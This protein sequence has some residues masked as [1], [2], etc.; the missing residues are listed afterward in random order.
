MK[1]PKPYSFKPLAL[2]CAL[3]IGTSA[4]DVFASGT[5]RI[6]SIDD[7][8]RRPV[9]DVKVT[10]TARDGSKSEHSGEG[11]SETIVV[12]GLDAGLY[13]ITI[14]H[15]NYYPLRLPS[16]RVID[17]KTTPLEAEL[18]ELRTTVEET[19]VIGSKV[20][21]NFLDPVSSSEKDREALRSS[22]GGGGDVLRSLDGLPGLF[23]DSAF[24]SY[25][26]R[27]NGPRDNLILVDGIPFADV[28]HFS[29]ALGEQE[30]LEGGGRYSVFAPNI[31]ANAEFQPGGWEPA[32]GGLAGSLL[33]LEVAEGN[34]DTPSYTVRFDV[35]G[36]EIG[37]DGPTYIHD[38]TSV[39]FSARSLD[40][41]RLFETI[42]ND[43]LGEPSL[44]DVIL[45]TS[46]RYEDDK[47]NFLLLHSTEDYRRDIKHVIASDEDEVG[48]YTN[49]SL[50]NTERDNALYALTWDHLLANNGELIQRFYYRTF[51][52]SSEIGEA[53]P[54]LVPV[55]SPESAVPTR[56]DL[57]YSMR[58]EKETGY[59]LD[60]AMPNALGRFS[61][62]LRVTQVDLDF[63]LDLRDDWIRYTYSFKDFRPSPEQKYVVWTEENTDNRYSQ[64]EIN[65]AVYLD[66][67]L[68]AGNWEF[69]AGLRYDRDNFSQENLYS[70]RAA[71]TWLPTSSLRVTTTVGRYTQEPTFAERASDAG[72]A[73]LE[74]ELVDQLSV[75]FAYTLGQNLELFVEPYYQQLNN[76]IAQPQDSLRELANTGEGRA[77]GVDTALSRSFEDGWSANIT[78]SYNDSKVKDTADGDYYDADFGRP[79]SVSLGGIWEI[80]K[81][82][83]ISARWKYASGKPS[84]SYV[85]H[86]DVLGPGE[87]LR[88]SRETVAF[89]TGR[90][91]AYSSLNMRFDYR[92]AFGRTNLIAFV[93]IINM[94]GAENPSN[95]NFNERSGEDVESE[96]NA[97]PLI[98]LRLE[99]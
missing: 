56:P 55:G 13:E 25:T 92:R 43:D 76:L 38:N 34:P 9:E 96:G 71:A 74:N 1:L 90:Y 47:I 77:F 18:I 66:Q 86:E 42:G 16:V 19:L 33:K 30:D 50:G 10:V 80:N 23:S 69:R 83:K 12:E 15:P 4:V 91:G 49:V 82:W 64:S 70:P 35:A 26:V 94:L 40:F 21:Q 36:L 61:S 53:Y 58:E 39:L 95:A 31:I 20:S 65:Y 22:A 3:I 97:V 60:F 75:G 59:R 24:S 67:N 52:E 5:I 2:A 89:N 41:T 93:D 68:S 27:G 57:L 29:D 98:G 32:Y 7:A 84:D 28:V 79:H 72:N 37:Y 73:Q 81:R 62:G 11:D 48:N 85:V 45:K 6:D 46:T 78:Y 51:N 8:S 87:P 63:A 99:W 14:R 54:D 44:T 17:A 88:Y